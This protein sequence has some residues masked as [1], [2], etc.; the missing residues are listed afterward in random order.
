MLRDIKADHP[1]S[2]CTASARPR[3]CTSPELS[4]IT[5]REVLDAPARRRARLAARRRRRDPR[6]PRA[7]A[8]QPQEGHER[9]VARRHA[10]G[11]R[12]RH[13]D[14]RDDDVRRPR[15]ASRS[16]SSTCAR[17]REVQDEAVAAGHVGF[18]AFIPWSFQP[19]NT[20]LAEDEF[21]ASGDPMTAA[22]GW[23]YLRTLAVSRLFLDNVR[24]HPGEL[25]HAGRARSGRSR[26]ASAPT[27]WARR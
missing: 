8:R 24:Q 4:G 20:A 25:G 13:L 12:A 5:T 21:A 19:G 10:R 7:R 17:V 14:D 15:D 1:R 23:E 26:C 22:S 18:R 9:R 11:P 6:R 2:T 16:A 3:S 27:T